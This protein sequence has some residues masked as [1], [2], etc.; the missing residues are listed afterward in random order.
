MHCKTEGKE[1]VPRSL[2]RS[3]LH[4]GFIRSV[5]GIAN[6]KMLG[7]SV[8]LDTARFLRVTWEKRDLFTT[9]PDIFV[10]THRGS[11]KFQSEWS[12]ST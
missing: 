7:N 12:I 4:M 6:I 2:K 11:S 1:R 10:S 9:F 5:G 3:F 8:S